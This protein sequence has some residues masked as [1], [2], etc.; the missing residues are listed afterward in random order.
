MKQSEV[1]TLAHRISAERFAPCRAA[2]GNGTRR[3][4]QLYERNLELSMAFWGGGRAATG[5][6]ALPAD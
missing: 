4:L 1:Q 2:A 5:I 6:L 3:A